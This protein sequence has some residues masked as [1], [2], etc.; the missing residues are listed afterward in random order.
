M[1][2][3]PCRK[4]EEVS[5]VCTWQ[6]SVLGREYSRCKCPEAE[7]CLVWGTVRRHECIAGEGEYSRR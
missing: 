7:A 2:L 6:I 4:S 3:W 1:S 5:Q